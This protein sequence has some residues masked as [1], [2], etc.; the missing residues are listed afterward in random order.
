MLRCFPYGFLAV[1]ATAVLAVASPAQA[2]LT[3]NIYESGSDVIIAATGSLAIGNPVLP[4]GIACIDPGSIISV[5]ASICTGPSGIS[6]PFYAVTGPASFN[7]N[8]NLYLASSVSGI[9]TTFSGDPNTFIGTGFVGLPS[10]YSPGSPLFSSATFG[11]TTLATLGFTTTGLIGSW[12]LTDG[13]DT[14]NVVVGPTAVPAPLPLLGA[15]AA[16]SFSRRLRRRVRLGRS[17]PVDQG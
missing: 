17:T 11:S 3:Y 9:A 4:G 5:S 2:V 1:G 6:L 14:I 15:G 16:L 12:T 13:G 8:A 7:D 10:T